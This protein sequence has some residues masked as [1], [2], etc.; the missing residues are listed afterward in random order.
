MKCRFCGCDDGRNQCDEFDRLQ[1]LN[2]E[3]AKR[4]RNYLEAVGRPNPQTFAF[5]RRDLIDIAERIEKGLG[6]PLV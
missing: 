5:A 3:A 2:T 6:A 4:I 1:E